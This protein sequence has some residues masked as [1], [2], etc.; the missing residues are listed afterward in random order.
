MKNP[1]NDT[2][3]IYRH[4][5][6]AILRRAVQDARLSDE[7][8]AME[9]RCWLSSHYARELLDWVA[10]GLEI[11]LAAWVEKLEN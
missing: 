4:I 7:A 2:D 11:D 3:D 5:A 8:V 10:P 1:P 9:A 6:A